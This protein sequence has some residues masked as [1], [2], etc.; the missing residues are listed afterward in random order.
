[1]VVVVLVAIPLQE[2][3]IVVIAM[4]GVDVEYPDVLNIVVCR[5][6]GTFIRFYFRMILVC[7]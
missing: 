1:M 5:L 3:D 7:F 2:I 4:V 6:F